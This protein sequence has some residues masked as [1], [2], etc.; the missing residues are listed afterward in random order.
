MFYLIYSEDV[1]NSLEKRLSV[2]DLHLARLRDLEKEGRLL[3]AGP[4]PAIDS[5]DPGIAGFTGSLVIAEFNSLEQ[6]QAW[7]DV[8]PYIAAGVYEK[9]TVKPYKKVLP[10]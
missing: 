7:A 10:A 2:R 4:C 3:V 6:A 5:N 9:V 1:K 8:D